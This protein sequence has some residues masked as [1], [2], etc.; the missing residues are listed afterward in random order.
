[1]VI[2]S[3]PHRQH[4]V[5]SQGSNHWK[6]SRN[7]G[8][9][10]G[11]LYENSTPHRTRRICR[12]CQRSSC[13]DYLPQWYQP[14]NCFEYSEFTILNESPREDRLCPLLLDYSEPWSGIS[15]AHPT[16]KITRSNDAVNG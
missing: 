6:L 11:L 13:R 7:H 15:V 9:P 8:E 12:W 1:M 2:M 14:G 16:Q 4:E 3:L 5:E 10:Y